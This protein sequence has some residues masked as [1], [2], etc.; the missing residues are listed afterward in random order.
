MGPPGKGFA[1][2]ESMPPRN[3]QLVPRG[4]ANGLPLVALHDKQHVA[5]QLG[6]GDDRIEPGRFLLKGRP[7]K[8][9]TPIAPAP[10]PALLAAAPLVAVV[11]AAVVAA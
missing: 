11:V 1:S 8:A 10:A 2:A 7:N 9:Q 6:A 4:H 5:E 3:H